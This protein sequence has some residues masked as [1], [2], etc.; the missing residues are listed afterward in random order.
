M[1]RNLVLGW[2]LTGIVQEND[3][4]NVHKER[5]GLGVIHGNELGGK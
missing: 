4:K 1:R 3:I 2:G 5:E